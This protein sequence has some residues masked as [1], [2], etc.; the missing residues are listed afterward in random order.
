L[1]LTFPQVFFLLVSI[2]LPL[3]AICLDSLTSHGW[4]TQICLFLNPFVIRW[5]LLYL[6]KIG[7]KYHFFLHAIQLLK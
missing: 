3:W 7:D 1:F 4:T 5:L 2:P 6:C